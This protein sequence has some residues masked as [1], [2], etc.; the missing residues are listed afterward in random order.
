MVYL[1]E[2]QKFTRMAIARFFDCPLCI[3]IPEGER[4]RFLEGFDYTVRT[5]ARDEIVFRQGE[6]CRF[7]YILLEGEVKAEMTDDSGAMLRIE[8]IRAPRALAP[9]FLFAED[10]HFPVTATVAEAIEVFIATKES[11][12]RQLGSSEVFMRNF[13]A[14]NSN[15]TT[16]LTGR[17]QFLSFKTIRGKLI[18]YILELASTGKEKVMLDKSQQEL[19]EYFGVTRP[20]LA[21]VLYELADE[22]LITVNRREITILDRQALRRAIM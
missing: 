7:L 21:K 6:P 8:T 3:G 18:H 19:A 14:V 20:A 22:G 12:F 13:L 4:E 2:Y 9:A 10:N 11:V 17:L 1:R 15:R 16:F 5:Y